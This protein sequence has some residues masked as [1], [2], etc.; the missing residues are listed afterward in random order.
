MESTLL[1]SHIGAPQTY[2]YVVTAS[3]NAAEL[4]KATCP[5]TEPGI[6]LTQFARMSKVNSDKKEARKL[7]K[8]DYSFLSVG[9]RAWKVTKPPKAQEEEEAHLGLY[10][11]CL[12][13]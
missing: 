2:I 8:V 7:D 1:R 10:C 12:E 3:Q 9:R 13:H 11:S 4:Q 6:P 5:N